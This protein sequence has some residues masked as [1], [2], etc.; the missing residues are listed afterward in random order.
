MEQDI[1]NL[2]HPT[3]QYLT[4]LDKNFLLI[5]V[6]DNADAKISYKELQS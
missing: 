5:D 4:N 3:K 1:A 2:T 6:L